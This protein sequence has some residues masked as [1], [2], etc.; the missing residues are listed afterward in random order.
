[1]VKS[2]SDCIT[3]RG[4][5]P[6][7]F[8]PIIGKLRTHGALFVI[9]LGSTV[10]RALELQGLHFPT[11]L[12]QLSDQKFFSSPW[13]KLLLPFN[14]GDGFYAWTATGLVLTT[15]LDL[16]VGTKPSFLILNAALIC[17]SYIASWIAFRSRTFSV[18]LAVTMGFGSQLTYAYVIPSLVKY[19]LFLGYLQ[20]NLLCL[21]LILRADLSLPPGERKP[22]AWAV[23]VF[24]GTLIALALCSELW[25]DYCLFLLASFAYVG[26]RLAPLAGLQARRTLRLAGITF[27]VLFLYLV[28]RLAYV[29][30][31][32]VYG[33]EGEIIFK[34]LFPME[35][36]SVTFR[37]KLAVLL[38]E[39]FVSNVFS[40]LY[41]AFSNFF[42]PPFLASNSLVFLGKERI[43]AEQYGYHA[44]QTQL[45]F[46]HHVFY[47][48]FA[49]GA[50]A[51]T[52][53]IG[54]VAS[55]RRDR[56]AAAAGGVPL[57]TLLLLLILCGFFTHSVI[58]YRPYLSSP[59]FTYKCI[60]S[61]VGVAWLISYAAMKLRESLPSTRSGVVVL[62]VVLIV[63]SNAFT[64]PSVLSTLSAAVGMG[65]F[66][67]PWQNLRAVLRR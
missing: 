1:M 7:P 49:A 35:S 51:A 61:V 18:T 36:G 33:K 52:F 26:L 6:N 19:F 16:L 20:V 11:Y 50:V 27:G 41:L 8:E 22:P 29:D 57:I 62:L 32:F 44:A 43:V 34:Y 21:I 28:V 25:L 58:K 56:T 66:P 12:S 30:E 31:H 38:V 48:Y 54:L 37:P 3:V 42:P 64:R 24:V 10:L 63:C 65:G 46:Y 2:E 40:Y 15:T 4:A 23:P 13:W 59:V 39:D 47:W 45:V 14:V 67:N 5:A 55:I 9:V 53:A 17:T 60:V